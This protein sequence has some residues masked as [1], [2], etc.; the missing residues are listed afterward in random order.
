MSGADFGQAAWLGLLS[1]RWGR[2]CSDCARNSLNE[3]DNGVLVASTGWHGSGRHVVSARRR[4]QPS[5]TEHETIDLLH[6]RFPEQIISRNSDVNWT[7]RSCDLTTCD[8]FL[9]GCVKSRVYANK[10][11]TIP[12]LKSEIQRVICEIQ[13]HLCEKVMEYFMKRVMTCHQSLGGHLTDILF[14]T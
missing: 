4:H 2:S 11:E 13:P 7:P 9:W 14:H 5:H 10:P 1:R 12:E 8:F 3:H 6:Q